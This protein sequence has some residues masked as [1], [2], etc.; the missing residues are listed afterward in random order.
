[1]ELQ[2]TKLGKSVIKD[3]IDELADKI[4]ELQRILADYKAVWEG[5]FNMAEPLPMNKADPITKKTGVYQIV[6]K[7]SKIIYYVGKGVIS[8]RRNK[9]QLVFNN[10]GNE[11]WA[12]GCKTDSPVARK[13]YPKD[14]D[15][16]NWE[17]WYTRIPQADFMSAYEEVL[18][19]KIEPEFNSIVMAGKG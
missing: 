9:H 18:I 11:W 4:K 19:N 1:M 6:Y 16:S 3:K 8:D 7:P 14:S 2:Y 15:L 10:A 12:N 13:M 5:P 17:F